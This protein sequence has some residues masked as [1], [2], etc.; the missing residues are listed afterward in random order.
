MLERGA[1]GCCKPGPEKSHKHKRWAPPQPHIRTTAMTSKRYTGQHRTRGVQRPTSRPWQCLVDIMP[2]P[3]KFAVKKALICAVRQNSDGGHEL[4]KRRVQPASP[5]AQTRLNPSRFGT[6]ASLD[7]HSQLSSLTVNSALRWLE[8]RNSAR[9]PMT[10]RVLLVDG[11]DCTPST[12]ERFT[13]G[14]AISVMLGHV[15]QSDLQ[16]QRSSRQLGLL[17][18]I[19]G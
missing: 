3:D 19:S 7:N 13:K 10:V 16:W 11:N 18:R 5:I 2:F 9:A 12:N 17:M 1:S 8:T 4:C 6:T 14:M 15:A